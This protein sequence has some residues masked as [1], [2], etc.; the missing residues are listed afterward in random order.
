[1]LIPESRSINTKACGSESGRIFVVR[2]AEATTGH[3][4]HLADLLIAC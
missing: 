2:T 1:V 4:S 3:L